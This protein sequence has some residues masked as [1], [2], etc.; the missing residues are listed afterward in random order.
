MDK[1]ERL[2]DNLVSRLIITTSLTL[3]LREKHISLKGQFH[4]IFFAPGFF[5]ESIREMYG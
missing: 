4:E 1:L 3:S 2:L 5:H